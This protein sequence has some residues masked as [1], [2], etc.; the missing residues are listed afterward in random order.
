MQEHL[1]HFRTL[2]HRLFLDRVPEPVFLHGLQKDRRLIAAGVGEECLSAW[3]EELRH[4]IGEDLGVL[5]FV[6]HV[7]GEYEVESSDTPDFRRPPVE[8]GRIRLLTQVSTYIVDGEVEGGFV[9]VRRQYCRAAGERDDSGKADTA[10][11]F[12]GAGIRKV[13][14]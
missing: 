12:D 7:G 11:E 1:Y 6:E 9:V 8:E 5:A 2:L 3:H 10:P 4:Q 14:F 13:A